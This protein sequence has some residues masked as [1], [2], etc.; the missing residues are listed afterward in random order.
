MT[1]THPKIPIRSMLFVPGN[2]TAWAPKALAAGADAIV[3]D[4]EDAVPEAEK[5][6]AREAVAQYLQHRETEPA[7][8]RINALADRR[9]LDDLQAIV[10]PKLTGILVPKVET[11]AEI[12][13]VERLLD[14]LESD[15][16]MAR[17]SVR[18][19]PVFETALGIRQAHEIA[20]SPRVAYAGGLGVKGGDVERS[21]GYRW[22]AEGT[23]TLFVRSAVLVDVRAAGVHNPM[24]GLWTDVNDLVGLRRFAEQ[25]RGL[26]YEGMLAIHPSHIPI[27][28]DVFTPSDAELNWAEG[29]LQA[30]DTAAAAGSGTA[31]YQGHMVD[32]AMVTTARA[33]LA[34]YRTNNPDVRR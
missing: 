14:W 3:F 10:G 27:I 23:E 25:S 26:G 24:T 5:P 2:R 28:N 22:T 8:V 6:A 4:L 13:L 34:R 18:I 1:I 19:V 31:S 17:G 30:M 9:A 20:T 11:P 15:A 32:E 29:L 12:A 21:L 16:C 33:R 7:F